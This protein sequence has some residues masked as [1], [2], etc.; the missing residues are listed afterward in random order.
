VCAECSAAA[1]DKPPRAWTDAWGPR[2]PDS[3]ADGSPL[4]LVPVGYRPAA[5]IPADQAPA[6][7]DTVPA[8]PPWPAGLA[9]AV[10][11]VT[12]A[13][14]RM[15]ASAVTGSGA[16]ADPRAVVA[17]LVATVHAVA[18]CCHRME[19]AT[20]AASGRAGRRI[21]QATGAAEHLAVRLTDVSNA[22]DQ[23]HTGMSTT[24][25]RSDASSATV[26]D[27]VTEVSTDGHG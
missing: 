18:D 14:H 5:P 3:H 17:A 9:A 23:T 13:V 11:A 16:L 6:A 20:A 24:D 26:S 8:G 27:A 19:A 2:P 4:C 25:R 15:A 7:R 22:L 12:A 1:H 21:V 10:R